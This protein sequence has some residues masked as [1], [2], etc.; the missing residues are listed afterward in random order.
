[1]RKKVI[2]VPGWGAGPDIWAQLENALADKCEFVHIPWHEAVKNGIDESLLSGGVILAGWSLG[3]LAVLKAACNNPQGVSGLWLFSATGRLAA[4]TGYEGVEE[5]VLKAM[6]MKLKKNRNE[7]IKEFAENCV[8]PATG[9]ANL[10]AKLAEKFSQYDDAVLND[11]LDFLRTVDVRA[12]A[13]GI[14]IPTLIMH[15]SYD[16]IIPVSQAQRLAIDIKGSRPVILEA[17]HGILWSHGSEIA[18]AAGECIR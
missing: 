2:A 17:G 3:A 9:V 18:K 10:S 7:V 16:K 4:D 8:Y 12:G 1:M 11:G 14:K 15:G 5:K 6:I 13:A